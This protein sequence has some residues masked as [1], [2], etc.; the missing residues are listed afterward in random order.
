LIEATLKARSAS[1]PTWSLADVLKHGL[2]AR[3]HYAHVRADEPRLSL[4]LDRVAVDW[5]SETFAIGR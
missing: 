4:R 2:E 5:P 1:I 3:P